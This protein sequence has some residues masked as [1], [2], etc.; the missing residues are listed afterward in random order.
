MELDYGSDDVAGSSLF[1]PTKSALPPPTK[2][3]PR[4]LSKPYD[5]PS[6]H[7]DD[8]RAQRASRPG[9]RDT[10][11]LSP[12]LPSPFLPKALVRSPNI[13]PSIH[14]D[15]SSPTRTERRHF[16]SPAVFSSPAIDSPSADHQLLE[17]IRPSL[18]DVP[19]TDTVSQIE[20]S[21]PPSA[22]PSSKPAIESKPVPSERNEP[23]DVKPKI[24]QDDLK[25]DI[26]P[27][28]E[29]EDSKPDV[30]PKL[31]EDVKPDVVERRR[32]SPAPFRAP[33]PPPLPI[34]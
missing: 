18:S 28:L 5:R 7:F 34:D 26:K 4:I 15:G 3:S 32:R 6:S 8:R 20:S 1:L 19:G 33:T 25:P 10:M 29:D 23:V 21:P 27:K 12:N 22:P 14:L 13:S 17:L 11:S 9:A 16:I 2:L 24:G 31:E 30:K